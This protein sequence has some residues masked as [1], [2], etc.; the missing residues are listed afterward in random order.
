LPAHRQLDVGIV[1]LAQ[2]VRKSRADPFSILY[3]QGDLTAVTAS[4]FSLAGA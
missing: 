4:R 2:G 1:P 3:G